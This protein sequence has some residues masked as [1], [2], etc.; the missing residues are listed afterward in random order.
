MLRL[1]NPGTDTL[2]FALHEAMSGTS[3]SV[4]RSEEQQVQPPEQKDGPLPVAGP[5]AGKGRG[6]PDAFGYTWIDSDEP[7]GPA[8][9]WTDI[10]ATGTPVTTWTGSADDGSVTVTLP[11]GFP[12]YGLCYSSLKI[13]TNGWIGFEVSSTTNAY[14]NGPIPAS[15]TEPNS[16]IYGWWDDLNVSS[17]G[18]VHYLDDAA[19]GRFIV[20]YTN[21][22]HYGTTTPGLYTFQVILT[23]AG[24]I[25][26]QYLDMQQTLNSAT[27][28]IESPDGTIGLQVAYNAA[29][30]HNNLAVLL[31]QDMIPWMSSAADRGTLAPGDSVDIDVMA[32]PGVLAPGTYAAALLITGNCPDTI[33]R[34]RP[35]RARDRRCRRA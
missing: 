20:Q 4:V 10:S 17:G 18:T 25:L 7:G 9:A 11:F 13:C 27:I 12:Y 15:A 23:P 28:G 14:S 26:L 16:A 2:H 29:Y 3:V 35:A 22:P 5:P 8:F 19:N 24:T 30:V 33:A 1:R 21:V 34:A 6:G 32:H 31:T